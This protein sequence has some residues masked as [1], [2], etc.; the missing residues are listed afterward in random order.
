LDGAGTATGGWAGA[1]SAPDEVNV[2]AGGVEGNAAEAAATSDRTFYRPWDTMG[3][4]DGDA[5]WYSVDVYSGDFG[6]GTVYVSLF[7]E[8]VW[9]MGFQI[10]GGQ[11]KPQIGAFDTGG[12]IALT[13]G[14]WHTIVGKIT[15]SDTAGQ[16]RSEIWVDPVGTPVEGT[17]E[18]NTG[19]V[20]TGR[21]DQAF[22]VKVKSGM[23]IRLDNLS[24]VPEPATL[25]VLALGGLALVRRR[26]V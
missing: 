8:G 3:T 23:T 19:S 12:G 4:D 1:W 17:G 15:F 25:S 20:D 22:G 13:D 24:I 26:R 11:A 2:V 21:I 7:E 18:L 16:D 5:Y 10:S 6:G 9:G 14:Q